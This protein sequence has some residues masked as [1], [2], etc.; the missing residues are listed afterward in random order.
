MATNPNCRAKTCRERLATLPFSENLT[1]QQTER[2]HSLLADVQDVRGPLDVALPAASRAHRSVPGFG[3]SEMRLAPS[4]STRRAEQAMCASR[5]GP[6]AACRKERSRAPLC[7]P[8]PSGV[9]TAPIPTQI[10]AQ[11][12]CHSGAPR[13]VS[14]SLPQVRRRRR[15]VVVV[16]RVGANYPSAVGRNLGM[17]RLDQVRGGLIREMAI[18]G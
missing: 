1:S 14:S 12:R 16:I 18:A 15:V 3:H 10:Q 9:V 13:A 4:T 8:K 11:I 17:R 6:A 5:G 2:L 7:H